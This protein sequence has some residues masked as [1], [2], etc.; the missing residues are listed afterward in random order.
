MALLG[1]ANPIGVVLSAILIGFLQVVGGIMLQTSKV[2]SSVINV[3][4]GF[5]IIFVIISFFVQDRVNATSRKKEVLSRK[6]NEGQEAS[7]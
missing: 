4:E 5:V 2:P 6:K 3:T 7:S 1:S